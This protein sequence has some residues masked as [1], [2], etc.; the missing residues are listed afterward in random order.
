MIRIES[1]SKVYTSASEPV[2]AL[3]NVSCCIPDGQM[4]AFAGPSGSGKT[5][6]LNLI[7]CLDTVSAGHI[8]VADLDIATLDRKGKQRFRQRQV[9]FIFQNYNLIPVLS[10]IENVELA[11]DALSKDH[12]AQLGLLSRADKHDACRQMLAM[13]GLSGLEQR[14]PNELSGGQQQRISIA[15]ALV[16]HPAV[17]LADEPTANLDST[18]GRMILDLITSLNAKQGVTCIFSSHDACVL[19][20]MQRVVTL[21]DGAIVGDVLC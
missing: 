11:L 13:V 9:G 14:R 3:D 17:L 12:L 7:G 20:H 2:R 4:M 19:E 15:R 1:V 16:K 6:M 10:A 5:T 8:V 21:V 18:N